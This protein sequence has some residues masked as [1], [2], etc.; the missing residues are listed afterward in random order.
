MTVV[1]DALA[2]IGVPAVHALAL[3][4]ATGD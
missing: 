1:A 4:T 2:T 3:A